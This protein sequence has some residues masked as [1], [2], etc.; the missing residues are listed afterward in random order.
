MMICFLETPTQ[1]KS[2]CIIYTPTAKVSI[3]DNSLF[4]KALEQLSY[5]H[6]NL[7]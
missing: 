3:V 2:M 6:L 7:N 5:L 1:I 4:L